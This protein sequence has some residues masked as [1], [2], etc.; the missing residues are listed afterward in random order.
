MDQE[1]R[2]GYT[3]YEMDRVYAYHEPDCY[4]VVYCFIDYY[5]HRFDQ[6]VKNNLIYAGII[7]ATLL[8]KII[9]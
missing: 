9:K 5:D 7:F 3:A 2:S 1:K 8:R 6:G 4:P